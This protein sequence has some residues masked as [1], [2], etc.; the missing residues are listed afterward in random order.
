MFKNEEEDGHGDGEGYSVVEKQH[1]F[2]AVEEDED[3]KEFMSL[4]WNPNL[5]F[6][7]SSTWSTSPRN[8][9]AEAF[10][11]YASPAGSSSY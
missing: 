9:A 10:V 2:H 11:V 3:L 6:F 7:A 8:I 1:A 5:D 4:N